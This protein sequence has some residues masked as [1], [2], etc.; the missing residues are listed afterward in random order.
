MEIISRNTI[1]YLQCIGIKLVNSDFIHKN[2]ILYYF[3]NGKSEFTSVT[4]SA[5]II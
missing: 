1:S 3:L 5:D 2:K 4:S